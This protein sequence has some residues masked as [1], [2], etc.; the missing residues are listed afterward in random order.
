MDIIRRSEVEKTILPGRVAQTAVGKTA[1]SKSKKMT[2]GYGRFDIG[3]GHAEPHFHA[4]ESVYIVSAK[5]SWIDFGRSK[6]DLDN[7]VTLEPGMILH[8]AENEWHRFDF[9][10]GG[11]IDIVFFYAQIDNIRPEEK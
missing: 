7:R 3:S 9:G 10:E 11:H 6:D 5:N 2:L 4:E 8:I 1:A